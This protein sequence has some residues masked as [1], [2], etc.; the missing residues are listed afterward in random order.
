MRDDMPISR[1][2]SGVDTWIGR[3]RPAPRN[4][5]IGVTAATE[6]A[7]S[8]HRVV[9]ASGM[10]QRTTP[11]PSVQSFSS[12]LSMAPASLVRAPSSSS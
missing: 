9:P 1:A 12:T 3:R 5:L 4:P 6:T 2:L 10:H 7:V 11:P 8:R